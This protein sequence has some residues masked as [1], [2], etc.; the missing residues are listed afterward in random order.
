VKMKLGLPVAAAESDEM[1]LS[2]SVKTSHTSQPDKTYTHFTL[3]VA[4]A[5]NKTPLCERGLFC[6]LRANH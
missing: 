3:R 6:L 5:Q 1:R 4:P 2:R